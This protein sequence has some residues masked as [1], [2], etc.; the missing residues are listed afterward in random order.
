MASKFLRPQKWWI[1]FRHPQTGKMIRESLNTHDAV[2]A[3]LLRSRIEV[4][5]QLMEPRLQNVEL[6]EHLSKLLSPVPLLYS[7]VASLLP[8][9][10]VIPERQPLVI[11]KPSRT[12]TT[13]IYDFI[14]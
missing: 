3:E 10:L 11:T 4:P 14:R 6:P 8:A 2:R 12:R 5:V 7:V 9:P 13:A 1:K